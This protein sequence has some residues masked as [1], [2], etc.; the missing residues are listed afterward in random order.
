MTWIA[1]ALSADAKE[2]AKSGSA[3]NSYNIQAAADYLESRNGHALLVY[4]NDELVFEEYYNGHSADKAHRLASGT[5]SFSGVLAVMAEE[6]GLLDL[7]EKVSDTL[8]EWKQDPQMSK[9]TI[10]QLISLS[11]GIQGGDNQNTPSGKASVAMANSTSDPGTSFSYGPVPFQSWGELLRRKLQHK[12][13]TV[14][15]YM[16]R[17]LLDPIG[18][19]AAFWRKDED[20]GIH[21]P[22]GAFI[23][24]REWSKFGLF[25][26]A[27]GSWKGKE[28]LSKENLK[29]CFE[30]SEANANYG[31]TFWLN[32]WDD[33]PRD[34]VMAAG[35]GKQ[36][37]YIIPSEDL[38]IVQMAEAQGYNEKAFLDRFFSKPGTQFDNGLAD[39]AKATAREPYHVSNNRLASAQ[40]LARLR[41]MDTNKDNQL[42]EKEAKDWKFFA[43]A[44]A[45][46]DG[47]ATGREIGAFLQKSRSQE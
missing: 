26:L 15:D 24:A 2:S 43:E 16:K 17:R 31:L 47:I 41:S 11:S 45:N 28:L 6:D 18:L 34:L 27:G 38:L 8:T 30:G 3:A 36:K 13:E 44:D 42:S 46:Q 14:E 4:K 1:C 40:D 37:L 12:G 22:A 9:V 32:R 19:K 33:V 23:T 20:G 29:Q 35:K 7:D 25:V 21:M 39:G 5:K 10:R